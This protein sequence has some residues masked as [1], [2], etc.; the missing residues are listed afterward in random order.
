MADSST[1]AQLILQLVIWLF[2]PEPSL[3]LIA[4]GITGGLTLALAPQLRN[5]RLAHL[6]FGVTWLWAFGCIAEVVSLSKMPLQY[7]VPSV[8]LATVLIGVLALLSY[9]W[10][11]TNHHEGISTTPSVSPVRITGIFLDPIILGKPITLIVRIVN[12]SDSTVKIISK[13]TAGWVETLPNETEHST[14]DKY[15]NDVWQQLNYSK[16]MTIGDTTSDSPAALS[17]PR[18]LEVN[19]TD[20]SLII[21]SKEIVQK[22]NDRS[23]L[24]FCGTFTDAS[25]GTMTRFCVRIDKHRDRALSLCRNYN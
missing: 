8:F 11:E 17:L 21:A 22:L 15:E 23:G 19:I 16:P 12:D 25:T 6:F 20:P 5:I 13:Y 9:Q 4:I 3:W 14:I 24:Y 2:S 18:K 7:T 1:A 10:V